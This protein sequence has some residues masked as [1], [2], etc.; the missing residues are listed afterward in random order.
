MFIRPTIA[1]VI[2][3]Y[4]GARFI[5]EA[6]GSVLAQ[7]FPPNEIIVVDDGSQDEG[8]EIVAR[9][10]QI[11]LVRKA[12]GG[13]SSARNFGVRHATSDLIAFLD[14]DDI[15]YPAHLEYLVKPFQKSHPRPLG[16]VYS[17]LDEMDAQGRTVHRSLLHFLGAQH[18]KRSLGECLARDMYILPSAS[19]ISR[20]AFERVGGFD[21]RLSGYEDDDL[22]LRLFCAG[23]DHVFIDESLSRWRIYPD[24]SSYTPRMAQSRMLYAEKLLAMFPPDPARGDYYGRDLIAPRFI[25]QIIPE[26]VKGIRQRDREMLQIARDH[27]ARLVFYLPLRKRLRFSLALLVLRS[28]TLARLVY[29]TRRAVLGLRVAH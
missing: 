21:E 23:Y 8:P 7:T 16:W 26:C 28:A 14:Q 19:L 2:P 12:N 4:N 15:W 10:K 3:L 18:P 24:S 6:I 1:A 17:N 25:A 29:H 27:L 5:E 11:K 22:F 9:Y 20:A 13:Q